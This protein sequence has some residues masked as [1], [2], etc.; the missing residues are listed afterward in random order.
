MAERHLNLITCR[1]KDEEEEE[2]GCGHAASECHLSL[3][4]R[5]WLTDIRELMQ[6]WWDGRELDELSL[7]IYIYI[8]MPPG[9]VPR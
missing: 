5:V 1:E 8:C 4:V 2:N 9:V 7:A 6:R 3:T